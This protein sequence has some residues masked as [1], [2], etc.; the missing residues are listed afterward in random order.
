MAGGGRFSRSLKGWLAA[1]LPSSDDA[2]VAAGESARALAGTV[3]AA[4]TTGRKVRRKARALKDVVVGES[5]YIPKLSA[6]DDDGRHGVMAALARNLPRAGAGYAFSLVLFAACAA[7][8]LVMGGGYERMLALYGTPKD[9]AARMIGFDISHVSVSGAVEL[10]EQEVVNLSGV[11]SANS[12]AFLDATAVQDKLLS[13]PL[14]AEAEVRKLFPNRLS[15]QI[16]ERTPFALWQKDGNLH[17][18]SQDGAIIDEMK[19]DRF[20]RLPHVVGIGA[21]ARAG[22]YIA[23]LAAAGD[24]APKIRAGVLVS[25]RRWNLKLANGIDIKLPETNADT[26]LKELARLDR[27]AQVL[28]KAILSVD[29]RLPGRAAFRLTEEAAAL[30]LETVKSMIERKKK[31]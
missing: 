7:A 5:V 9:I 23:L 13:D 6:Q 30:R 31:A 20:T 10:T 17:L 1:W 28:D 18:V 14:I 27:E 2:R 8:G 24:L 21:N 4:Q 22:E 29:L 25:E 11:T 19:D 15:I 12:L 16:K 26:A 3:K